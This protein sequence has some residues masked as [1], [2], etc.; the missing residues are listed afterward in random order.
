MKKLFLLLFLV[1]AL[2][3]FAQQ[4]Q[5]QPVPQQQQATQPAQQTT[6]KNVNIN[7][8]ITT[9]E[10]KPIVA[11]QPC[12]LVAAGEHRYNQGVA[13]FA[14]K[15]YFA[16]RDGYNLPPSDVKLKYRQKDL[17]K[18]MASGV[19]VVVIDRDSK[20]TTDARISCQ[21]QVAQK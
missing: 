6:T 16:Y 7:A 4:A 15:E 10:A 12:L 2:P 9:N 13:M 3:F 19:K 8:N 18:M 17:E 20:E 14:S 11:T 21:G 1:S 5:D